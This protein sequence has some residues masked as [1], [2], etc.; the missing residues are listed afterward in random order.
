MSNERDNTDD[1]DIL[2]PE[3]VGSPPANASGPDRLADAPLVDP[4]ARVPVPPVMSPAEIDKRAE[5]VEE[6][7]EDR[8]RVADANRDDRPPEPR[9]DERDRDEG[10]K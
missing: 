9:R 1:R 6:L 2:D 10:M 7:R 5:V 3:D 8:S 4:A